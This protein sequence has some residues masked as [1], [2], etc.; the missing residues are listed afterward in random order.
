MLIL[1]SLAKNRPKD[2]D[3]IIFQY[4]GIA[5]PRKIRQLIKD[6]KSAGFVHISTEGS[7]RKFE[8]AEG[9]VVILSGKEGG[10]AFPYQERDVRRAT[11]E[12]AQIKKNEEPNNENQR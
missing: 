2:L 12:Q 4:H 7:H 5:M 1:S 6:L 9:R 3:G 8:N 11:T 10:D